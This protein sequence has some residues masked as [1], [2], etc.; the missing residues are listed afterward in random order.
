MTN[1]MPRQKNGGQVSPSAECMFPSGSPLIRR[2][3]RVTELH[4]AQL[5]PVHPHQ[6][7]TISD[8]CFGPSLLKKW[9]THACYLRFLVIRKE[10]DLQ[11]LFHIEN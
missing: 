11:V 10:Y 4:V 2:A 9:L 6:S 5:P 8:R 1:P 7:W 3:G